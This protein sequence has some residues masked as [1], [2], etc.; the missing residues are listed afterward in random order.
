LNEEQLAAFERL[1]RALP[2]APATLG[3]S[4]GALLEARYRGDVVRPGIALYGGNPF[5]GP[6]ENP[7][8]TGAT[9]AAP[10]VRIPGVAGTQTGRDGATYV[11]TAPARLAI[12]GAGYADGYPRALGNRGSAAIAGT[13][14]PVVG[15]VS[16]DLTCVDVTALPRDV[17]RVGAPVELIGATV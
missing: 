14:V 16:M 10:S 13:R 1:R 15:R 6:R 7:M 3:N 12:V 5:A 4:A 17:A 9:L 2:A 8:E 11:A